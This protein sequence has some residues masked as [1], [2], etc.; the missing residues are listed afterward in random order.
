M[1]IRFALKSTDKQKGEERQMLSPDTLN[2]ALERSVH[3]LLM[4]AKFYQKH[5]YHRQAQE[6]YYY[7][8]TIQERRE[9]PK[10]LA[11]KGD[12]TL[13]GDR[14]STSAS[15]GLHSQRSLRQPKDRQN[16]LVGNKAKQSGKS[17]K[18]GGCALKRN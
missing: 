1:N 12:R 13:T 15:A 7:I 8:L 11:S 14:P 18:E 10:N 16:Y 9:K 3:E 5:G 4:L 6:I 17:I 2:D